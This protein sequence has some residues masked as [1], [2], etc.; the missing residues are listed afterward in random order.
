MIGRVFCAAL[1]GLFSTATLFA[2]E[3]GPPSNGQEGLEFTVKSIQNGP[4]SDP[5]T[6]QPG[7]VPKQGDR[8]LISQKTQ[9]LY[10]VKSPEVIRLIQ[11]AGTLR[12]SRKQDTEL[13]VALLK[14]QNSLSCSESGFACDFLSVNK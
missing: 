12:F 13:N 1:L 7:R 9:V 5:K 6:W 10:D 2:Q 4:W 3:Q 14:V 11:V 8:V